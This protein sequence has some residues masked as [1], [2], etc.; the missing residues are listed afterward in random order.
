[1]LREADLTELEQALEA[2]HRLIDVRSPDEFAHGRIPGAELVP[3]PE[4]PHRT[5]DLTVAQPLYV[6]CRSGNRSAHAAVLLARAGIDARSVVG[7]TD[8]WQRSGRPVETGGL[9]ST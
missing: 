5:A 3:L 1:M 7:G 2:G 9:P 6:V 8:A 4:L